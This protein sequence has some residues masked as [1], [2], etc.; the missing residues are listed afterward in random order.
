MGMLQ[1]SLLSKTP[2]EFNM[3]AAWALSLSRLKA[4]PSPD[5]IRFADLILLM[6]L[7]EYF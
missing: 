1:R 7:G 5:V 4:T 3:I 6:G 2:R